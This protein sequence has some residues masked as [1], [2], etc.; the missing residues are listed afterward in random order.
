ME[1]SLEGPVCQPLL[2]EAPGA[3]LGLRTPPLPFI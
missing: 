2:R 1:G 3:T